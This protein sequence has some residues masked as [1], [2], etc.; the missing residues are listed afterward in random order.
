VRLNSRKVLK[1]IISG[2]GFPSGSEQDVCR[3]I[4]KLAK[5]GLSLVT[6]ELI[7]KGYPKH[8]AE[9]LTALLKQKTFGAEGIAFLRK[10]V[11]QSPMLDEGLQEIETICTLLN[12]MQVS[13]ESAV[14]DFTLARGLDYYTGP[15]FEADLIDKPHIG[16]VA[17]GGRYDDLVGL[18]LKE[19]IPAVGVSFGLERI[20]SIVK[21]GQGA[22]E[23]TDSGLDC[24]MSF[25]SIEQRAECLR[26]A[27][28]LRNW[29][30]RVEM[31]YK[32]DSMKKQFSYADKKRIPYV[33]VYGPDEHRSGIVAVKT[34][35]TGTQET[36]PRAQLQD[37]AKR[38]ISQ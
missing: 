5:E 24:L 35:K 19:S 1:G 11:S 36:I 22:L 23:D 25:F 15:I 4:D 27:R 14:F 38:I 6:S 26:I 16:S 30:L 8:M 33:I 7:K 12:E 28:D 32:P 31:Y 18:F 17:G 21:S 3:S 37:F 13:S 10:T 9:P 29:G 34:M 2:L 20:F